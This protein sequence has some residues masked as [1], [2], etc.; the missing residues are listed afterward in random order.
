MAY[1][2]GRTYIYM[3]VSDGLLHIHDGSGGE[4]KLSYED[5]ELSALTFLERDCPRYLSRRGLNALKRK[6][7]RY[8]AEMDKSA[9]A[10]HADIMARVAKLQAG[11]G[12]TPPTA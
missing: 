10:C 5:L 7:R 8:D 2:R 12:E 1:L 6:M 4:V 3:S 11:R 9:A